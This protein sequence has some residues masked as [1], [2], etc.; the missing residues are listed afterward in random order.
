MLL[1]AVVVVVVVNNCQGLCL[2]FV[3]MSIYLTCPTKKVYMFLNTYIRGII[4]NCT[5]N[6]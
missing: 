3:L 4:P 2:V 6:T 5:N 1:I